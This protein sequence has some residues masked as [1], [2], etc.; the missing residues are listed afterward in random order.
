MAIIRFPET[1]R[2]TGSPRSSLYWY[3]RCGLFVKPVKIGP[4][5]SGFPEHEVDAIVAARVA[6]KSDAEI[7]ELVADLHARRAMSAAPAPTNEAA[8]A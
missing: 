1:Q 7:R 6:G 2:K 8:A 4:R 5:S 3:M